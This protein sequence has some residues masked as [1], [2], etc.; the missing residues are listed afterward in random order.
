MNRNELKSVWEAEEKASFQGWDFSRLNGRWQ[1]ESL[2]WDYKSIVQMY[3][4]S[5]MRL[6]DMGTGGGEF[7]LTLNHPYL[8]TFATEGW[9]PNYLL[10]KEKLEPLGITVKKVDEDNKLPYET[11]FFDIVINRHESYDISEVKRILKPNGLMITQ[12]VGGGNNFDLSSRLIDGYT[13]P[14]PDIYLKKQVQLIESSG[15]Q[16]KYQ[17]EEFPKLR[18]YDT[19]AI[20]YYAKIVPWEFPGFSVSNCFDKLLVINSELQERGYF[21]CFQQRFI[22]VATNIK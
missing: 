20:V 16:I 1:E 15:F 6:L 2:S 3:L 5:D 4:N 22:I 13:P 19:G 18:F 14:Y 21:E 10:C 11:N 12:Q 17:K 9:E 8:C 7:L